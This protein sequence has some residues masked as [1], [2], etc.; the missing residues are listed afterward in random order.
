MRLRALLPGL[1]GLGV[2][3]ASSPS[4]DYKERIAALVEGKTASHGG[5]SGDVWLRVPDA[6]KDKVPHLDTEAGLHS[7]DNVEPLKNIVELAQIAADNGKWGDYVFLHNAF[8]MNAHADNVKVS[9]ESMKE[10]LRM[11]VAGNDNREPDAALI[12]LYA[13]TASSPDLAAAFKSLQKP[14]VSV[15]TKRWDKVQCSDR[16]KATRQ[17]CNVLIGGISRATRRKKGG[18]RHFCFRDCCISWSRNANFQV[19]ALSNA[20]RGCLKECGGVGNTVSCKVFG[21]E[22]EGTR[23]NQCL[24]NR[25]NGCD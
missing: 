17:W 16:Y 13:N 23:C 15:L 6:V 19:S 11:A 10:G 14:G 12:N 5:V 18:P 24:S 25:S 20:A 3:S 8:S 1:L 2:V 7:K 21:V 9:S 4:P 22:L